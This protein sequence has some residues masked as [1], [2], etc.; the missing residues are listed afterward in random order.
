[1]DNGAVNWQYRMEQ[2]LE[3]I[4]AR[5][6][7]ETPLKGAAET[8][9]CSPFYFMRM[10][11]VIT[12]ISPAEYV[13]RRR[14]SRAALEIASGTA[15]ILDIALK[16]GY[17]SPDSFTRAFK[18]EFGCL[19]TEA[20]A[21]G[22]RLHTYPPLRFSIALKGDTPME[23]RIEQEAEMKLTGPVIRVDS[24]NGN[25]F[26]KIPAFWEELM[27]D[28]RS[29]RM[30][31]MAAN[32]PLGIAGLCFDLNMD[33]GEFT[34]GAMIESSCA[35]DGSKEGWEQVTIPAGTWAKFTSR[36]P[37]HPNFQDMIKRIYAEWFPESG[38]EHAGTAELEFYPKGLNPASPD[39]WCEYW[40]PI[41]T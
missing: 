36:G 29:A 32:S 3:Y 14:L 8:A 23:F 6:E 15:R 20:R 26:V 5:L 9:H 21:G 27:A 22:V 40:V 35:P 39:Y 30:A 33:T 4:E 24:T 41:K 31:E 1:M 11:E 25:N 28:G 16:Y 17:E 10:F 2:A 13:R 18:R 7:N 19:P 34:Y 12:G 38:R 37:L